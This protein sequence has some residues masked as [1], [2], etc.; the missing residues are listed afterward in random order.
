MDRVNPAL[1]R[2]AGASPIPFVESHAFDED[3]TRHAAWS[4]PALVTNIEKRLEDKQPYTFTLSQTETCF[5]LS[6]V[7]S[8]DKA[9]MHVHFERLA[10]NEWY[11]RNGQ[12][13]ND[14]ILGRIILRM[15]HWEDGM[16]AP[17]PLKVS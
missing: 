10:N 15:M 7:R 8:G 12:D 4:G 3:I 5:R 17:T 6:Y 9:I 11:Y 13:N 14:P 1:I 2:P 16:V